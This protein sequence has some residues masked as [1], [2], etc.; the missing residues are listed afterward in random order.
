MGKNLVREDLF[1]GG[2]NLHMNLSDRFVHGFLWAMGLLILDV[3]KAQLFS[4]VFHFDRQR[5][6]G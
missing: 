2:G 4:M 6:D 1:K 3:L 5:D